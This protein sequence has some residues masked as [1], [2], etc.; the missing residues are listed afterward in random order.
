MFVLSLE[1]NVSC[2]L[3]CLTSNL[4]LDTLGAD[5]V[6][7]QFGTSSSLGVNSSSNANLLFA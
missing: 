6:E 7:N 5:I 4:D 1:W 2:R 3:L